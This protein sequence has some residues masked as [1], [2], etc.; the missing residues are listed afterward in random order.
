MFCKSKHEIFRF[1][2]LKKVL[3]GSL[4]IK[5]RKNITEGDIS[6]YPVPSSMD[7]FWM[8]MV[9]LTVKFYTFLYASCPYWWVV[10]IP[11]LIH[12]LINFF[13]TQVYGYAYESKL[14]VLD[15]LPL[16][17][18]SDT[19]VFC[20]VELSVIIILKFFK[21]RQSSLRKYTKLVAA[22]T[23]CEVPLR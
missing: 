2:F 3:F 15:H 9:E 7:I 22:K 21:K 16:L 20:L 8:N 5:N 13:Q 18:F 23:D 4:K 11:F 12:V 14:C 6:W 1:F 19:H 17:S 10:A